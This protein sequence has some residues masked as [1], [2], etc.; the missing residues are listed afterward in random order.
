MDIDNKKA[1]SLI[2]E[3]VKRLGF[4]D[5]RIDLAW[6]C[7]PEETII[8]GVV[9]ASHFVEETKMAEIT[10]LDKQYYES[11][12]KAFSFDFEETLVHELMHLKVCLLV[13]K[14]NDLQARM[15]HQLIDDMAKALV[16][17]KRN[18]KI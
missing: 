17:A 5:W 12:S 14:D 10:I 9:G 3:W 1:T 18:E 4:Q 6:K 8:P 15:M 16:N 13:Q 11:D 7:K 2:N